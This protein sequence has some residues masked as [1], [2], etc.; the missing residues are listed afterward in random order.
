MTN[1]NLTKMTHTHRRY[2]KGCP[3]CELNN[4]YIG[5]ITREGATQDEQDKAR[6]AYIARDLEALQAM[7]TD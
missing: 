6:T 4:L 5:V 3:L 7:Q 1:K 2:V